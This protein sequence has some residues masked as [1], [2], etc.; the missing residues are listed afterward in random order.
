MHT[1]IVLDLACAPLQGNSA[2]QTHSNAFK[3]ANVVVKAKVNHLHLL[4]LLLH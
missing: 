4:Q 2:S 1:V 3:G